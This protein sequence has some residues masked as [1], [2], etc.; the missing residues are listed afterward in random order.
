MFDDLSGQD[1]CCRICATEISLAAYRR[2]ALCID[3]EVDQEAER[4]PDEFPEL[5]MPDAPAA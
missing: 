2:F 1:L 5:L 4:L 3:C